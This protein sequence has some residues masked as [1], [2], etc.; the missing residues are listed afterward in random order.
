MLRI[1][2]AD[3]RDSVV[4]ITSEDVF[5]NIVEYRPI[6]LD[7]DVSKPGEQ[8][9]RPNMTVRQAIAV[10]GGYDIASRR[11][12]N[13]L[14]E[15]ADLRGQ[16]EGLRSEIVQKQ[17]RI[18]RLQAE[19][20]G[21]TTFNL[22]TVGGGHVD[23][24]ALTRVRDIETNLLNAREADFNREKDYL[25]GALKQAEHR[26]STLNAQ[27]KQESE[28]V[29]L[30]AAELDRVKGL[31][32]KGQGTVI[33]VTDA[34]RAL[35]LSSTR[36][37]QTTALAT[38]VEIQRDEFSRRL[39]KVD[40]ARQIEVLKELQIENADLDAVK[41]R[42]K[43]VEEKLV[44]VEGARSG[45]VGESDSGKPELIIFRINERGE[46]QIEAGQDMLLLPGDIVHVT[47]RS[48]LPVP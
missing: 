14:I 31:L 32:D 39:Q 41:S 22:I 26:L 20:D 17:A 42:L 45:L 4:P 48:K 47:L 18:A 1:R 5:V 2:T 10:A 28:G 37:L 38:Q 21:K 43:A 44:Y 25:R 23:A 29:L 9:Y 33:R 12:N 40:D 34:R 8:A 16:Y 35:L 6:F 36:Q 19:L 27:Q 11:M 24:Q 30:D 3:A 13:S 15:L 7:G 46:E